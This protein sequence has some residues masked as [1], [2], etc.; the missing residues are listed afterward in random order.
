MVLLATNVY[1]LYVAR[2]I[3]GIT[4]SGALFVIPVFV[5]EIADDR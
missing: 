2:M 3:I 1:H 5:S 4:G